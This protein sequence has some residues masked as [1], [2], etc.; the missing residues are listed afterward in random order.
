MIDSLAAALWA[1]HHASSFEEGAL[2]A[3]NLGDDADSTGAVYGQL[4][5]AYFGVQ[6]IPLRWRQRLAL[7]EMIEDYA[8]ALYHFSCA[9]PP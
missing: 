4:A 8:D 9:S 3:V 5:G 1:F 7:S 6:G 2:L